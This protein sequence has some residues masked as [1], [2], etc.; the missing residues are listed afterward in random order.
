MLVSSKFCPPLFHTRDFQSTGVTAN[1]L[2]NLLLWEIITTPTSIPFHSTSYSNDF[3]ILRRAQ[4]QAITRFS[5]RIQSLC[6]FVSFLPE[7]FDVRLWPSIPCQVHFGIAIAHI[8]WRS[9]PNVLPSDER[10]AVFNHLSDL[11]LGF[12]RQHVDDRRF[13]RYSPRRGRTRHR[14]WKPP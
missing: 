5:L 12:A 7:S 4:R 14:R 10:R 9:C 8:D 13:P 1:A 3:F 6:S 11:R 2:V